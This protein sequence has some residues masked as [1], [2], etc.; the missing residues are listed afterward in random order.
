MLIE[1]LLFLVQEEGLEPPPLS[2]LDPKS[3]ASANF[4][5]LALC[6]SI[7]YLYH[8][9]FGS[10]LILFAS[11]RLCQIAVPVIL[12]SLLRWSYYACPC[13]TAWQATKDILRF[14]K[15]QVNIASRAI[16]S[17][18]LAVPYEALAKYGGPYRNRTYNIQ[19]KS[20]LLYQLS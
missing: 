19:I 6:S 9:T 15:R 18:K 1:M 11:F 13:F 2:G 3:S 7:T 20:L 4:A 16:I 17:K 5:T 12:D 8:T 10:G 14:C